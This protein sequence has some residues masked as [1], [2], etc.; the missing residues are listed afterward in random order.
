MYV[1]V[2]CTELCHYYGFKGEIISEGIFNLVPSSKKVPNHCSSTFSFYVEKMK[3]SDLVGFF[4]DGAKLK[5][6][7]EISPLL[8]IT[9]KLKSDRKLHTGQF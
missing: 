6:L 9:M 4:D 8:T 5:T 3:D 1:Y 2:N 7:S